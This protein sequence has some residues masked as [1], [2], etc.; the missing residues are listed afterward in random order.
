MIKV[1]LAK[2]HNYTSRG[3]ET[4]IESDRV[5]LA[6]GDV[7]PVAKVGCIVLFTI[8]LIGYE[9]YKLS[10]KMDERKAIAVRLS[11]VKQDIQNFGTVKNVIEDLVKERSKLN[12]QLRVIRKISQKRAFKLKTIKK[13]QESLPEDLWLKQLIISKE[14][15]MFEGY[16]RTPSSV[17]NIVAQL[18]KEEFVE[19]AI[20]T[21]LKR[22]KIGEETVNEFQIEAVVL[23]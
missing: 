23:K 6:E 13:V 17:Q 4:A 2:T 20:N 5:A 18:E 8:L 16:S 9:K 19:S 7:S 3:T 22:S 15:L 14:T 11:K 10:E 21:E 1:N 12:E